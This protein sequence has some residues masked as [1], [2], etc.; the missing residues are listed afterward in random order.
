MPAFEKEHEG[1]S[2]VDKFSVVLETSGLHA[3]E[4]S[5]YIRQKGLYPEQVLQRQQASQDAIENLIL[6][7]NCRLTG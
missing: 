4:L 5:G 2:A 1:W 6:Q 7:C 3:T